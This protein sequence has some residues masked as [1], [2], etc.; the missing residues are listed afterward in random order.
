MAAKIADPPSPLL[1][2]LIPCDLV[3]EDRYTGKASI[4]G[5]FE[6]IEPNVYPFC[7]PT[8]SLFCQLTNGHGNVTIDVAIVDTRENDS[9]V[10]ERKV[11]YQFKDPLE[12]ANIVCVLI[13][14]VFSHEGEYRIVLKKGTETLGERRIVCGEVKQ[15]EGGEEYVPE[16][17]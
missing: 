17:E 12:I 9:V 2:N 14:V 1:V 6:Y 10:F 16:T 8:F 11:D 15:R 4:I 3:I 5:V 13:N 7:M